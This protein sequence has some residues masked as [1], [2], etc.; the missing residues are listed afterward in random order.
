MS[1]PPITPPVP[2]SVF[3]YED[4]PDLLQSLQWMIKAYKDFRVVGAKQLANDVIEDMKACKPDV[5]LM[6]IDMPETSG[7]E[8]LKKI[9][10]NF[11]DIEV[12]MLTIFD[13]NENIF[14]CIQAGASGYL[15]K[16][17]LPERI[18]EAIRDV[19]EGGAPMTPVVAKKALALLTKVS[20]E[21]KNTAGLTPREQ[22]VL[23]YLTKGFSYKMIA[24]ELQIS[25][26]TVRHFIKGVY[27][28]LHVNSMAEAISKA[29]KDRLV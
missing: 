22:Q 4:N 7:L 5:V 6:D 9:K 14:N 12:L 24:H 8:A 29:M 13:S 20:G 26:D 3:I 1:Q 21:S 28:K 19:K 17:T 23:S 27:K 2:I 25:I 18:M 11:E 16:G 10:S 15:L